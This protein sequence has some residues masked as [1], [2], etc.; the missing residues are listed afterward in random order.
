MMISGSLAF[1]LL[2]ATSVRQVEAPPTLKPLIAE[3][4]S[5]LF[6]GNSYMANYGGVN[7]LLQRQLAY[8][9]PSLK[10]TTQSEIIYGRPLR[11]MFTPQAEELIQTKKFD[12]VVIT[13]G[14]LGTMKKFNVLIRANGGRTVVYMTWAGLHPGNNATMD[15]YRASTAADVKTMRQME[16]DT[17]ALI[18]P[19]AVVYHDLISRPPREGLREDYLWRPADIH[20]NFLGTAVNAW[21]LYAALTGRSPVDVDLDYTANLPDW[22]PARLA[23]DD[24]EL[25]RD[26][27][28][29][30]AVRERVW[31]IVRQWQSGTTEFD[32]ALAAE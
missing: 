23:A 2:L 12:P 13:S 14:D 3:E 31:K 18:V 20:Q 21:T 5:L 28:L 27:E 6:I 15:A 22:L 25:A 7:N 17:G 24:L 32:D 4:S 19:V 30:R 1:G 11:E 8:A 16:R 10:I 9:S 29:G 26:A